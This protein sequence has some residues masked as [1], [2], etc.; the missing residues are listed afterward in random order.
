MSYNLYIETRTLESGENEKIVVAQD[1]NSSS[2]EDISVAIDYTSYVSRITEAV[3]NISAKMTTIDSNIENTS[4]KMTTIDSNIE[5]IS[6]KMTT[7]DSNIEA[8]KEAGDPRSTGDGI[9]TQQPFN[10]IGTTILYLLYVKQAQMIEEEFA[11]VADQEKSI[12]RIKDLLQEITS[13]FD[14][15]GF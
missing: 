5:N 4:A 1:S 12:Q 7:I 13:E 9:R 10:Y 15:T 3:E 8:L 11:S 2:T 6:A 14:S